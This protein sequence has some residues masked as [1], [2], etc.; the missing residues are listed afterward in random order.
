MM[1]VRQI[2]SGLVVTSLIGLFPIGS[3]GTEA[4]NKG[5]TEENAEVIQAAVKEK[6][7]DKPLVV[8]WNNG[9]LSVTIKEHSLREVFDA[10]GKQ[11]PLKVYFRQSEVSALE[12]KSSA[13]EKKLSITFRDLPVEE[14]IKRILKDISHLVKRANGDKE[15]QT[16]K[17]GSAPQGI[18]IWLVDGSGSYVENA[19]ASTAG[20]QEPVAEE[21]TGSL[22][23]ASTEELMQ[24]ALSAREPNVREQSLHHLGDQIEEARI[25][26][27]FVSALKDES[28][29]VRLTALRRLLLADQEAPI[30][31]LTDM[32]LKDPDPRLRKQALSVMVHKHGKAAEKT[33]EQFAQGPDPEINSHATKLLDRIHSQQTSPGEQTTSK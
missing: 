10:L 32:A 30:E 21:K 33:L 27:T 18:E 8:S 6:K 19:T 29:A 23:Q 11:M 17:G 2:L 24:K 13:Q 20:T 31:A 26:E 12:G 4:G 16:D 25:V 9:L 22:E 1:S 28:A 14:G 5:A 3:L 15:R 7:E